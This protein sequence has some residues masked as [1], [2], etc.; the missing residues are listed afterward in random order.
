MKQLTMIATLLV[1]ACSP[2][3][4]EPAANQTEKP[5]AREKPADVPSL[6]GEWS[7]TALGGKPL[8]QVFPMTAS[9]TADKATVHSECVTFAWSYTQDGNIVAFSP[10]STGHCGRNQTTNEN[11]IERALKG[12]NIALFSKE[13][14]EVQ[15][16][17]NGGTATL[18]RR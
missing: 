1:A 4:N 5:A 6:A 18:T 9:I 8:Q 16:S 3:A 17:G 14:R 11:E 15:L 7:V 12:A 13:G 10:M 2:S